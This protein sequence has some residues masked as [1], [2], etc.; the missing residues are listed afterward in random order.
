MRIIVGL[1]NFGE[2]LETML[3]NLSI[4]F[5]ETKDHFYKK[6]SEKGFE[7]GIAKGI[8]K[9]IEKGI[10]KGIEKGVEIERVKQR[11][12]L[13]QKVIEAYKKGYSIDLIADIFKLNKTEIREIINYEL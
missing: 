6:G 2:I 5:D 13:E 12:E 11:K 3:S 4:H 8:A 10:G 1:R 9:G 7:K